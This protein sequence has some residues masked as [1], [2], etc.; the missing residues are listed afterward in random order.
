MVSHTII[1]S[2]RWVALLTSLTLIFSA[3]AVEA[4]SDDVAAVE[5]TISIVS[6]LEGETVSGTVEVS[7]EVDGFVLAPDQFGQANVDGFGHWHAFIDGVETSDLLGMSGVETLAISVDGLE[8]GPHTIFAVLVDNMHVPLDPPISAQVEV[9]V[10]DAASVAGDADT[11]GI[12]LQ[13]FL[14]DPAE[15]TLEAGSYTFDASNDGSIDHAL[16]LEGEG[17]SAGTPDAAYASGTS[18]SFTV[19]LAPG[20]Y[21]IFCPVPGHRAAG[22]VGT[23]T[24]SG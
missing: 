16:A 23:I 4:Q 18:E 1:R 5:P 21:Q 3:L 12:S 7:V 17:I 14:L 9:E 6:P 13:E 19:E 22:M 10:G 20:T 15:L 2:A 11:V 8:P 24:V